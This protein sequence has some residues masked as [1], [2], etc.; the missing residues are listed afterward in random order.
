M[1]CQNCKK[2]EATTH[3]KR[4]V[5]GESTEAHLCADCAKAL[6]MPMHFRI[7]GLGFPICSARS[8]HLRQS[9]R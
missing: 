5:N 1:L 3:I 7:S 4:I 2:H 9:A 8:L 6:A